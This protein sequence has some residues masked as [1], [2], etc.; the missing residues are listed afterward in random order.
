[1]NKSG[2]R[3]VCEW[4]VIAPMAIMNMKGPFYLFTHFTTAKTHK[5]L[6]I[7]NSKAKHWSKSKRKA[8][9]YNLLLRSPIMSSGRGQRSK[10]SLDIAYKGIL[11]SQT[12]PQFEGIPGRDVQSPT[13]A[14]MSP[15]DFLPKVP[16]E[17]RP[18][19]DRVGQQGDS[20]RTFVKPSWMQV[21]PDY[22]TNWVRSVHLSV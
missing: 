22:R 20:K 6:K 14:A 11:G 21:N 3:E 19:W 9:A 18:L 4:D 2:K 1:M 8:C 12:L 7:Q 16:L 5:L 15:T 10:S 13:S 17:D